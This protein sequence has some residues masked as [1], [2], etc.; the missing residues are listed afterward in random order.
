V[1]RTPVG[2]RAGARNSERQQLVLFQ[3]NFAKPH[4]SKQEKNNLIQRSN[5]IRRLERLSLSHNE[6]L[7]SVGPQVSVPK[8]S[9]TLSV[10]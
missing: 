8:T 5:T 3:K 10:S 4:K 9:N 2:Y 1:L 6:G 7:M